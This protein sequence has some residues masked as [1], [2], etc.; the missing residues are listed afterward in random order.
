MNV[1]LVL[2][3]LALGLAIGENILLRLELRRE[4]ERR[5]RAEERNRLLAEAEHRTS[6]P[7]PW[8]VLC[9][10]RHPRRFNRCTLLPGHA[11]DHNDARGPVSWNRA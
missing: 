8:D 5:L 11:G 4:Q 1:P 7:P 2:L 9:G 10:A 6:T 3:G